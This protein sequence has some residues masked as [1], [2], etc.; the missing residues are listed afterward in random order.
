[1]IIEI[2]TAK[3]TITY[4]EK[5]TIVKKQLLEIKKRSEMYGTEF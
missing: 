2:P 4:Q 3:K 1:V 5:D